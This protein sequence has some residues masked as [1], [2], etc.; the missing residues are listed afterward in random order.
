MSTGMRCRSGQILPLWLRQVCFFVFF[1]NYANNWVVGF[2]SKGQV[3]VYNK[4]IP[5]FA[6]RANVLLHTFCSSMLIS[7]CSSTTSPSLFLSLDGLPYMESS[8]NFRT[9]HLHPTFEVAITV[10]FICLFLNF[11]F[12]S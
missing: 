1:S 7:P 4:I 6:G 10:L 9:L 12:L 11:T 5:R 3:I 8:I 2:M